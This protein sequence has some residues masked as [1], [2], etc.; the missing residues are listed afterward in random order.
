MRKDAA[1]NTRG[2]SQSVA[3]VIGVYCAASHES[4]SFMPR[5][6][7]TIRRIAVIPLPRIKPH[8]SPLLAMKPRRRKDITTNELAANLTACSVPSPRSAVT[9]SSTG[10][11]KKPL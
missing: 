2:A 3:S 1:Y 6:T 10:S 11:V 5:T 4:R 9:D 8:I 7:S